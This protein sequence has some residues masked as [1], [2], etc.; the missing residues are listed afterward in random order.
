MDRL[1]IDYLTI[2][3]IGHHLRESFLPFFSKIAI[4]SEKKVEK[5]LMLLLIVFLKNSKK[6][7]NKGN[8]DIFHHFI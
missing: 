8:D 2:K 5:L 4:A 1:T 3:L 6:G 7:I